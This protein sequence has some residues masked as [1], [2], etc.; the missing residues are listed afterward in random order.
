MGTEAR[1]SSQH[2]NS[3]VPVFGICKKPTYC[4]A[5]NNLQFYWN[6]ADTN[7]PTRVT[8][9][10]ATS[11]RTFILPYYLA[12]L[13]IEEDS[14]TLFLEQARKNVKTQDVSYFLTCIRK[15]LE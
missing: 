14:I 10:W 1:G 5:P 15:R 11:I 9:Q 7:T 2:M 3:D 12:F 6:I 4:F 8:K 13:R